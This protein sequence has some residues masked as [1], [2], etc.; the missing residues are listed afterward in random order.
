MN[1]AYEVEL[2]QITASF[3]LLPFDLVL[4]VEKQT[5][6][7]VEEVGGFNAFTDVEWQVIYTRVLIDDQWYILPQHLYDEVDDLYGD[8]I[9]ECLWTL[10]NTIV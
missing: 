5:T 9:G 1:E 10:T 8:Q 6:I 7:K 2:S 4:G 3:I